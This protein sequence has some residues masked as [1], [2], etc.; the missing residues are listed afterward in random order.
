MYYGTGGG[1][2]FISYGI[3]RPDDT[4]L[5]F[6]CSSGGV[7]TNLTVAGVIASGE[8]Q[9]PLSLGVT[10]GLGSTRAYKNGR[11]IAV[12]AGVS[13]LTYDTTA[14]FAFSH[15]F[16]TA[17]SSGAA[18][19]LVYV[20]GDALTPTDHALLA[21]DPGALVTPGRRAVAVGSPSTITDGLLT[22]T[23][24][25]ATVVAS[26]TVGGGAITAALTQTLAPLAAYARGAVGDHGL[27]VFIGGVTTAAVPVEVQSGIT[28]TGYTE[29]VTTLARA[30]AAPVTAGHY[31]VVL[32]HVFATDVAEGTVTDSQG[33]PYTLQV[34]SVAAE[35][36]DGFVAIYTAPIGASGACT[37][38]Y[39]KAG[40]PPQTMAMATVEVSG[41]ALA[42]A[43]TAGGSGVSAAP[44]SDPLVTTAPALRLAFTAA[45]PVFAT[46]TVGSGWTERAATT[47]PQTPASLL[48]R[49][50]PAGTD[51]ATWGVSESFG[52]HV[53]AMAVGSLPPAE[54]MFRHDSMS[55]RSTLNGRDTLSGVIDILDDRDP[56]M[57]NQEIVVTEDGVRI[58]GGVINELEYRAIT[59]DPD[60]SQDL[61]VSVSAEDFNALA[62]KRTVASLTVPEGATL[63]QALELLV[64][65][66]AAYGVTLSP[67]QVSGPVLPSL[68]FMLQTATAVLDELS[69]L[70]EYVW[71]IDA[72]QVLT[73]WQPGTV[74]APFNITDG[75]GKVWGD[76]VIR[77][78]ASGF[79]N[80]IIV[81]GPGNG[82]SENVFAWYTDGVTNVFL[83]YMFVLQHFGQVLVDTPLETVPGE[84]YESVGPPGSGAVWEFH[85]GPRYTQYLSRAAGAPPAGHP[86]G[87]VPYPLQ[88]RVIQEQP[89]VVTADDLVSQA[90]NGI[91]EKLVDRYEWRGVVGAASGSGRSLA[92]PC[93]TALHHP[94]FHARARVTGRAVHHDRD[95][96]PLA[97]RSVLHH[98]RGYADDRRDDS[99]AHRHGQRN[100]VVPGLVA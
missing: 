80:R 3:N 79:A 4:G 82:P 30:Y 76:I 81:R 9:Q 83:M 68:N 63:K 77:P 2:P 75:D 67:A 33:N 48:A 69:T 42:V 39:T 23:L 52:W 1:A 31:S 49:T 38:T 8:S 56:P 7:F 37:V 61:M 46:W 6:P 53:A 95:C 62:D 72:Y 19:A 21:A 65:E 84:S 71:E 100:G 25:A 88:F 41:T 92:S 43:A 47:F 57:L 66:L 16:I 91:V 55:I 86:W 12:G 97:V 64:P 32:M 89:I 10:W 14:G 20:F 34:E 51:A 60:A 24:A 73:M 96:P 85:D 54:W 90:A 11:E 93:V 58:F 29:T 50:A 94:V 26:G 74:A 5:W 59:S 18:P 27:R 40:A 13:G 44:T 98:R 28:A 87:V 15:N 35:P 17:Q 22:Q 70:T 45:I 99:Q 78:I 36:A